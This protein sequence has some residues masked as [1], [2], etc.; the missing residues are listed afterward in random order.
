M[1][2][3]FL[4]VDGDHKNRIDKTQTSYRPNNEKLFL[5]QNKIKRTKSAINDDS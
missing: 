1:R 4:F 2:Y 3:G 5:Q